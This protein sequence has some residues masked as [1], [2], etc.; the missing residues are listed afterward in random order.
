MWKTYQIDK[1]SLTNMTILNLH[2]CYAPKIK[3]KQDLSDEKPSAKKKRN[4]FFCG[5]LR[6]P[7]ITKFLHLKH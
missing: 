5:N 1:V 2:A 7:T 6:L 3:K 4:Q